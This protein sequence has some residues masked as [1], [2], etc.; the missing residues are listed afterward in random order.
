MKRALNKIRYNYYFSFI[1]SQLIKPFYNVLNKII[2]NI[3]K[4]IWVNGQIV[5][6]DGFKIRFPKNIG[7]PYSSNIFWKNTNGF[8]PENYRVLKQ[9]FLASNYFFDV[10]S[11]IGF[12]SVLSKKIIHS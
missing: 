3:Q 6:Y 9:L 1:V 2:N 5:T 12:Y 8:E 7:V 10:G 4:K 11:N